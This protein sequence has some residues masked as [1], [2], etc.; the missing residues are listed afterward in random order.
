MLLCVIWT[1]LRELD[2]KKTFWCLANCS[3]YSWQISSDLAILHL[4]LWVFRIPYIGLQW[5]PMLNVT[6]AVWVT[7]ESIVKRWYIPAGRMTISPFSTKI[8]IHLSSAFRISKY[9]LPSRIKRIS[10]SEWRCSVKKIFSYKKML[11][12]D[13][14][15]KH[16]CDNTS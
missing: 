9:P 16:L 5:P 6:K 15:S 13:V 2:N 10:S 8:R 4:I 3:C 7:F 1:L 14:N 11:N 12:F